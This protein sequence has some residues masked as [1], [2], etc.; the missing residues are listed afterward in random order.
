[1]PFERSV[2]LLSSCSF[3]LHSQP[4]FSAVTEALRTMSW[5]SCGSALKAA[6]LTMK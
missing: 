5:M 6:W 4:R 2:V 1:M 3:S